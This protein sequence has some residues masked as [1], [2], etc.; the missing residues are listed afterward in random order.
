MFLIITALILSTIL[1]G[2][3]IYAVPS[4]GKNLRL[5]LIFAGSYLF[6]ILPAATP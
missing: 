3:A 1:G 2:L 6:A 4:S 5:P